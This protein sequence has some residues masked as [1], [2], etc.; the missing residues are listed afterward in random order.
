LSADAAAADVPVEMSTAAEADSGSASAADCDSTAAADC[1]SSAAADC[2]SSA[3]ADCDSSAAARTPSTGSGE[4]AESAVPGDSSP[5]AFEDETRP[6]S[7][8]RKCSQAAVPKAWGV[9]EL[10]IE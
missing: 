6:P 7:R 10:T 8:D 2:D 1:D 9:R 5:G 4:T 3:A